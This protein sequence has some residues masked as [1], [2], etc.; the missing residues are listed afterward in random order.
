MGQVREFPDRI[1]PKYF[2]HGSSS[3]SGH[4][5]MVIVFNMVNEQETF[6]FVL[7]S[8]NIS[9]YRSRA[10]TC[11]ILFQPVSLSQVIGTFLILIRLA[12]CFDQLFVCVVIPGFG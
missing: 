10:V 4:Q 6:R 5:L 7:Y 2:Q 8:T 3:V 1:L 12:C 11:Q 9:C